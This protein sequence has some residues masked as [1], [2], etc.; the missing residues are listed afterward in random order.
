MK[1][2]SNVILIA[3]LCN[4][5]SRLY[6]AFN[7]LISLKCKGDLKQDYILVRQEL[8]YW[9]L[10]KLILYNTG[11]IQII[12]VVNQWVMKAFSSDRMIIY[13]EKSMTN[14]TILDING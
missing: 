1:I 5:C 9:I 14:D 8:V 13:K 12:R 6:L 11:C 2:I 4:P 7:S 3:T 10:I